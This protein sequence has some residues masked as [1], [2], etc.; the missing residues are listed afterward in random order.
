MPRDI[1]P[2]AADIPNVTLHN[3]DDI[4]SVVD[5]SIQK[6]QQSQPQVEAIVDD[7]VE[8]FAQWLRERRASSSV[9]RLREKGEAIRRSELDWAIP[10]LH[11]LS[12]GDRRIV[13]QMTS[14]LLNK[15]LDSPTRN[16]R[17]VIAAENGTDSRPLV[18]LLFDLDDEPSSAVAGERATRISENNDSD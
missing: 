8:R 2:L 17:E 14:R 1:D 4:Q 6:R 16:L 10:K 7:Q 5:G 15:L 9:R 3:L 18:D 13:D 12:E 11:H